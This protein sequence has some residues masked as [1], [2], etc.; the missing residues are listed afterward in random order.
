LLFCFF[1]SL[2]FIF[3][4]L[5]ALRFWL[6]F[7]SLSVT[8]LGLGPFLLT[9]LLLLFRFSLLNLRHI[10]LSLNYLSLFFCRLRGILFDNLMQRLLGGN[11][12]WFICLFDSSSLLIVFLNLHIFSFGH[13][14]GAVKGRKDTK[15]TLENRSVFLDLGNSL[16]QSKLVNVLLIEGTL[17]N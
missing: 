1:C 14:L 3:R 5:C 16:L 4:R 15:S 10:F 11:F 6:L 17:A 9:L 2:K 12:D 13:L 7:L 8:K